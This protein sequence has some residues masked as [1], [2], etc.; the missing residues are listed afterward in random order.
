MCQ[1][2]TA[3]SNVMTN[4]YNGHTSVSTYPFGPYVQYQGTAV[5]H[6]YN[7][8]DSTC[9][10]D[11]S[12]PL[13]QPDWCTGYWG[14]VSC[15]AYYSITSLSLTGSS[16]T[17]T[18]K[19]PTA[20]GA[21]TNLQTL[22]LNNMGLT[23]SIPNFMA[24]SRLTYLSLSNNLL[25]GVVPSFVAVVSSLSLSGPYLSNN[26]N[27]TSSDPTL[28]SQLYGPP[29]LC[30]NDRTTIAAEGQAICAI[31]HA[32]SNVRMNVYNGATNSYDQMP[33][34]TNSNGQ[35]SPQGPVNSACLYDISEPL[36][37]PDWCSGYWS[38]IGC[39]NNKVT[40]LGIN[41]GS[42]TNT[43][44]IPT[45]IGALTNL[46]SLSL[47]SMGLT[48][49]IP[50]F[51]G[52]RRL[53]YLSLQS[54]MLTGV[55]PSQFV[56]N[57]ISNVGYY[58]ALQN[59]CNLTSSNPAL[60]NQLNN[61]QVG[62]CSD[63]R[64]TI[65]A[66]GQAICKIAQAFSSVRISLYSYA[67]N[68]NVLKPVFS[69]VDSPMYGPITM[70]PT[71]SPTTFPTMSPTRYPTIHPT[72][73][74]TTSTMTLTASPTASPTWLPTRSGDLMATPTM[75]P[76][77]PMCYYNT[78]MPLHQPI[79]CSSWTGI[80]CSNNKVT[81]LQISGNS[82]S[83]SFN[84]GPSWTNT[85]KIPTAIG[86]LTNLQSLQLTNMG[87]TG[88]I[89]NLIGLSRLTRLDMSNNLL[90][91]V[92]P[93]FVNHTVHLFNSNNYLP[94]NIQLS[95][96]CNLTSSVPRIATRL[97]SQGASCQSDVM[98]IA[99]EGQA[100]CQIAQ[101]FSS[102]RISLYSYASYRNVLKPVFS[103]SYS[104]DAS[105]RYGYN[106]TN[107][108]CYYNTSM[109][110][111]Q[112]A[113]CT[114]WSGISCSNYKVT[115]LQIS[116]NSFSSSGS[117]GSSWTNTAKIPTVI[118]ALTNLQSLQLNNMGLTGSIPNL[119]GLSRLT[120]LS[121]YNNMLTGV[122]PKFVNHTFHLSNDNYYLPN[123][124]QLS[125]NCNLTSSVPRIATRLSSQGASCQS[126]V[127]AIAAEGQA[128]CQIAQA[129]SSVRISLYSYASY[130]NVLKPVFS[131]SYSGDASLRYGYNPT[132]S[133][134]YYNT[135]MPLHQP[136]WCTYWSGISCSNNK[137]TSLQI[138]GNSF[139]I[140]GNSGSFWT[141]T[142]KIPTAIGAL[143]NL[144]SLQ[145][146]NMGLTGSI[147]NLI[148]LSR[149]T[150][151]SLYNNMLTGVVP[152]FVNHTFHLSNDNYYLPNN[153]QL[154]SNCNLTSSVPRI[155]T[156][157]SSQGASCQSDV[158]AIA[159]EGQAICQIAQAFS[160]VR[161]SLYSYASYRNV[162]K[163]VFSKV[164]SPMY[165]PITM[166]PT[167]S[168]TTFPTM[169]PTR[170]PTIHPTAT[171]TTST[172]TLTAS[173][174]ASPTWLPT[175]SGDLMA[176]PTMSPADPMCYYDTSMPL[177]QPDWCSSWAGISCTNNR[178]TSLQIS[179]SSWNYTAKIPTA[180]GA[181][182]N[183][184]SLQL[185][186]MGLTGSIP[187]FMGLRQLTYL[188]LTNNMLTGVVPQFVNQTAYMGNDNHNN[189]IQLSSNCNLTSP[190]PWIANGLSGLQCKP[191]IEVIAAEGQA[192][193]AIAQAWSNLQVSQW[194]GYTPG[195]TTCEYSAYMF[196]KSL[197]GGVGYQPAW[198]SWPVV[199]CSNNRVSWLSMYGTY[200]T[201][202]SKIPSALGALGNLQSLS[203]NNMGLSGSIPNLL[204]LSK[205][206][207]LQLYNNQLTGAVPAFINTMTTRPNTAVN[208]QTN[209]NLTWTSTSPM[210]PNSYA[211]YG[212]QGN[213]APL[214]RG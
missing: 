127:M 47:N 131:N 192:M 179:A 113:W 32:L 156:R 29:G 136:A 17:N 108:T 83:N 167:A 13:H 115:S 149:L 49:S 148:G 14:G 80:S 8:S 57:I 165:G 160:S 45:A 93:K 33:V 91:G 114:Y 31:A 151:L 139:S 96:N 28:S 95:S 209:C 166:S 41:A 73:T 210:G 112:P 130:R 158:M 171:P 198:C 30:V 185:T 138:S 104:G 78:S 92:V 26:C 191:S 16:W 199:I 6:G 86:A 122:V 20:I 144:Q 76:A 7:P 203:L 190:T 168:P 146:T 23:S 12:L 111:H 181:L 212:G 69:K 135:S 177:H 59:N 97:S 42:W 35:T 176:T 175:R 85:A 213:C 164:D 24:L 44:K 170:Y 60:S 64:T 186:N 72:A 206:Q 74:P 66:E 62:A 71:A 172:M 200:L 103:N 178:V 116:G 126:D 68:R 180:I 141:N 197:N 98:A 153:I 70:S 143:T 128:I 174:T 189:V 102:V 132:N 84:F 211:N 56:N 51:M 125:S 155:A 90:T 106:P 3:L 21:F 169:S 201:K 119:I 140:S 25:T 4:V 110:L 134:C 105:L 9:Q 99:A 89:P 159:A 38:G 48:G 161:I 157:L 118:E 162:L 152:K 182:T 88:S 147:P 107:S 196:S 52:L 65:A 58:L 2:A 39:S 46:Q 207:T 214:K 36:Y 1:I 121:L 61:G 27:L 188:S 137:V 67:S 100:I 123:N 195:K 124:I 202:A 142:A 150:Y 5:K 77:D 81:S 187:N 173:P 194:T 79:W 154:S 11:T 82:F 184:R 18:A 120:Y 183:L 193:C 37:Q 133:T 10:Y 145:L 205:L 117:S 87:L 55:V 129:F 208:L 40:S 19:I 22:Q 43:A 204:G 53:T 94:N 50:N 63:D 34:F 101:A 75:S 109:P 15:D 54:N 163:P